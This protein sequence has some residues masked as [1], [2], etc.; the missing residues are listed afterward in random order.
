MLEASDGRIVAVLVYVPGT[1]DIP[2]I[3]RTVNEPRGN[4]AKE[5]KQE[6]LAPPKGSKESQWATKID[7]AMEIRKASAETRKGKPLAFPTRLAR[8]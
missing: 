2:S 3:M 4:M 7:R 8:H 5:R 6:S 1:C